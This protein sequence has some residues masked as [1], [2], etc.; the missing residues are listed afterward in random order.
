M[1]MISVS[2]SYGEVFAESDDRVL[3][4]HCLIDTASKLGAGAVR[5]VVIVLEVANP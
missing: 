4:V 1:T 3:Y 2:E 5:C